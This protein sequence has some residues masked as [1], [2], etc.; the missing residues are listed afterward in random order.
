MN[1]RYVNSRGE[2]LDFSEFPYLFQSG[3]LVNYSWK[4][5]SSNNRITNIRRE[6]GERAFKVGLIPDWTLP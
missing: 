3:D 6:V 4:Y 1:F 5:D 2:I